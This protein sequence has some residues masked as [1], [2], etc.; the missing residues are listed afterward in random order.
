V[1]RPRAV[2]Q[3]SGFDDVT[4]DIPYGLEPLRPEASGS[5]VGAELLLQK[6]LSEVPVFGLISASYN[7]TRFS[8][9]DGV[10]ARGAFDSPLVFNGLLGWRPNA[11]WELSARARSAAGLPTTPFT[12]SGQLDFARYNAG[13]RLPTFFA[14]DVRIDRRFVFKRSQLVTY[15]DVQNATSRQNISQITWDARTQR[16]LA[17]ESIGLLPSI[18]VNWEF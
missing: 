17:N 18:G 2:L 7:R 10:S 16:P 8:G 4:N 11:K 6:R 5:V 15:I 13:D 9:L 12:S 3:P 1:F 14:L